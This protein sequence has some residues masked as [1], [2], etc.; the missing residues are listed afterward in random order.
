MVAVTSAE[1]W[2]WPFY[3]RVLET[4]IL[5][6]KIALETGGAGNM[7]HFEDLEKALKH[8]KI[9]ILPVKYDSIHS[10]CS[11]VLWGRFINEYKSM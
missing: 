10:C 5:Y 1:F 4:E 6:S 8:S 3:V 7:F 11:C 9:N 2:I